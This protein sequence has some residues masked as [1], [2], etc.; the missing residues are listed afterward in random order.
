[1]DPSVGGHAGLEDM[2]DVYKEGSESLGNATVD[3]C[4]L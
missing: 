4:V 2:V 3:T 1:M